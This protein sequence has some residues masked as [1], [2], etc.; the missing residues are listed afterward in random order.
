MHGHLRHTS[1]HSLAMDRERTLSKDER[2]AAYFGERRSPTATPPK[3]ASPGLLPIS[4]RGSR[5]SPTPPPTSKPIVDAAPTPS[6][7]K[8]NPL[9]RN[10]SLGGS[11]AKPIVIREPAQANAE[12]RHTRQRS[13]SADVF[14]ATVERPPHLR[15]SPSHPPHGSSA[16][17]QTPTPL[18]DLPKSTDS[19]PPI[20]LAHA[21]TEPP[22]VPAKEQHL[23]AARRWFSQLPA[24]L[25]QRASIISMD[26]S[27]PPVTE[28]PARRR[29]GEVECIAYGTIDDQMMR[30]LEGRS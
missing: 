16:E 17:S 8:R 28:P 23:I 19:V 1:R 26:H 20:H 12:M 7:T 2:A 5:G 3:V 30:K 15:A 14:S 29:K 11:P 9:I 21:I 27:V 6:P 13:N 4:R 10:S 24:L 18:P 22:P 25:H